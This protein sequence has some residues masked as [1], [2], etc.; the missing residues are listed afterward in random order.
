MQ[1]LLQEGD[2]DQLQMMSIKMQR[3]FEEAA[4][5][6]EDKPKEADATKKPDG[7]K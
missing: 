7:G 1:R 5:P 3:A 2:P 4:R 6:P